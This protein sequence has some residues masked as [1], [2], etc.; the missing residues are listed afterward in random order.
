MF[1]IKKAAFTAVLITVLTGCASIRTNT[2]YYD[3]LLHDLAA[4]QKEEAVILVNSEKFTESFADK[5]LLL[6]KLERAMVFQYAGDYEKSLEEFE[7]AERIIE[8]AYTKSISKGATSLLLNDNALDYSGEVYENLYISVFKAL[9]YLNLNKFDEAYVE[10]RS[11][12]DKLK[13]LDIR[14]ENYIDALNSADSTDASIIMRDIDY[15]NN[16]LA[17]YLSFLIFRADREQDKARISLESFDQARK[18]YP[19]IYDFPSPDFIKNASFDNGNR[20]NFLIFAGQSPRKVPVGA[21]ITTFDGF[22]TVSDPSGY[23]VEPIFFPFARYGWNFKFEFPELR[24]EGTLVHD[25]EIEIP[26]VDT[27]RAELVEN[28]ANVARRTF[29]SSKSITFF[30][31]V[32]RSVLKGIAAGK[33]GQA[34]KKNSNDLLGFLAGTAANILSDISENAD[35]RSWITLP[36]YSFAAETEL[37]PGE[38]DVIINYLDSDGRL[39]KQ[40]IRRSFK[41]DKRLNLI[42]SYF[43]D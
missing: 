29:E 14:N 32:S 12:N 15:Y 33:I 40:D 8:D 25:I 27:L 42:N 5:D 26:G 39:L 16:A 1:S 4:G 9:N 41:A 34:V 24:E 28:I 35:L 21:R 2:D 11:V 3:P 18:T 43:F 20:I 7:S 23:W 30:K 6:L 10:I 38:Y 22:V 36:A 17:N 31:S 37:P 19:D 13:E